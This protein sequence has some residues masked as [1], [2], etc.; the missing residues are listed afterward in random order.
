MDLPK[1]CMLLNTFFL[2]QFCFRSLVWKF[3]SPGKNNK[4]SRHHEKYLQIIYSDK[5]ST[6]IRLL[7][8]DNS[9]SIHKRILG[10]YAIEVFKFKRD[11]DLALYKGMIPQNR[12]NSY[13][14]QNNADF[15][16]SFVKSFHKGLESLSY[17]G[18]K[19]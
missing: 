10:F 13:E 12:Q 4:I 3:H 16:L 17:L 18:P 14:L 19:I 1:R 15:I 5:K 2:S 7:G 8:K 11:L 6:F 9:V